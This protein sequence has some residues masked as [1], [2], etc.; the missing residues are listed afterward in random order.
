MSFSLDT[1]PHNGHIVK[2]SEKGFDL[3][4]VGE[5][6]KWCRINNIPDSSWRFIPGPGN[7]PSDYCIG[8]MFKF[9]Y[10]ADAISYALTFP[11]LIDRSNEN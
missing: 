7:D 8:N 11:Q 6:Q 2:I 5:L 3:L 4:N 9:K 1:S 10:M